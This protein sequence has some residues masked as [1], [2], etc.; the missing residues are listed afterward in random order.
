MWICVG[1]IFTGVPGILS[2]QDLHNIQADSK[3][4]VQHFR[5]SKGLSRSVNKPP[6]VAPK[7]IKLD[8]LIPQLCSPVRRFGR[9]CLPDTATNLFRN[10]LRPWIMAFSHLLNNLPRVWSTLRS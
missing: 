3:S 4:E 9:D 2:G 10:Q 1:L 6:R 7:I 8:S 5:H